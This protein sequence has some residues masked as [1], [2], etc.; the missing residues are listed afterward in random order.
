MNKH[1]ENYHIRV[2]GHLDQRWADWFGGFTLQASGED[3]DLF[4][5]VVDQAGLHG[6]LARIRDLGL[7]L[8]LVEHEG[9]LENDSQ[10]ER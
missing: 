9:R 5:S 1:A 8:L 3:T 4:G 6:I 7:V 10:E 2:R